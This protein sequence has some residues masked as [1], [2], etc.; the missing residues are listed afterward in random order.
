MLVPGNKVLLL[1]NPISG[2]GGGRLISGDLDQRFRSHGIPPETVVLAE[3]G[4]AEEIIRAK[5]RE[6][7]AVVAVGGDGTVA[8]VAGAVYSAGINRPIGVIPLG[9]S[10]CLARHFHLPLQPLQAADTVCGGESRPMDLAVVAGQAVF[11]FL[12]AGFDAAVV[13]KVATGRKGPIHDFAYVQSAMSVFFSRPWT[14][15]GVH[16]D[17]R[18]I[19]GRWFQII[20]SPINN[21]AHYFSLEEKNGFYAYLFQGSGGRHLLRTLARG[22]LRRRL[23]RACDLMIPVRERFRIETYSGRN[24]FYQFDGEAGGPL[25]VDGVIKRAAVEFIAP[26]AGLPDI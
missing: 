11:S 1:V 16:I 24:G 19:D 25:P 6:Y 15:L 21:Y 14:I 8:E 5:G 13:W 2:Q 3:P 26:P 17:G 18:P 23:E 7:Q 9:L 20:I 22:G 12:G 10:N 4:Q